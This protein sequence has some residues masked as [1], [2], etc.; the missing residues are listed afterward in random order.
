MQKEDIKKKK[1]FCS[2]YYQ[3]GNSAHNQLIV[4]KRSGGE[5]GLSI[6]III[7]PAIHCAPAVCQPMSNNLTRITA[8]EL[9][10]R[11]LS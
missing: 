2:F 5:L 10:C 9:R 6:I 7:I 8:F 3:L 11:L 1:D 4:R